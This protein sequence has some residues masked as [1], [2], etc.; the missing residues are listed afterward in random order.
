MEK[1]IVVIEITNRVVRLIIGEVV[2]DKPIILYQTSRPITGLISKGD[3]VDFDTLTQIVSSLAEISD[4]NLKTRFHIT[5]ATVILPAGGLSVFQADKTTNVV[6]Q[7]SIVET[8]DI[9]NVISL[10]TKEPIPGGNEI[11]DIVPDYFVTESGKF[12]E[13]PVGGKSNFLRLKCKVLTLPK[14]II[15]QY[16]QVILKA[17]IRPKRVCL[18]PYGIIE[19]AKQTNEFPKDYFLVDMGAQVSNISLVG[20][21]SLY[22]SMSFTLGGEDLVEFV[23]QEMQISNDEAREIVELYG[24]NE[25]QLTYKP[26]IA[27]AIINGVQVKYGP[28]D[29][30]RII[31]DFFS[32]SYFKQLDVVIEQIIADYSKDNLASL[33]IVFTGGFSSL[34]GFDKLAK[35]KF[36]SNQSL[37]YLEP[38]ALGV[39]SPSFS[40]LVGA[41]L[42]SS[43]YKGTLSDQRARVATVDRVDN[44]QQ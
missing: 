40:A 37:H 1:H 26:I 29:L 41:L 34:H 12:H 32:E 30:N 7:T 10:V 31:I 19:L 5:D 17:N 28:D 25:R 9:Q 18:A 23:A 33:P 22:A 20:N 36:S 24:I 21:H 43:K 27:K 8:I 6:S 35:E 38:D 16:R 39:R 13:P 2:N 42:A 11:V 15:D 44:K 14:R 4:P 3:I